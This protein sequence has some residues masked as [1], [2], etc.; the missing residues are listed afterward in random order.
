MTTPRQLAQMFDT[1]TS[2]ISA[3]ID[4]D[5]SGTDYWSS[6][7]GT[8][9]FPDAELTNKGVVTIVLELHSRGWPS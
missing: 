2:T 9:S 7:T 5:S 6:G 8:E 4:G 3:I 1:T